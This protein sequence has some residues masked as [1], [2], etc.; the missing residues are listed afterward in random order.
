MD[1]RSATPRIDPTA[2]VA[3][4]ATLIGRVEVGPQASVW[5]GCVLRGDEE[6]ITVGPGSNVQDLTIV[7][8]DPGYPAVIGR[9]VTIG[10]GAVIHGCVLEDGCLVGIGAILLTGSR[11]GAGAL[12]AAGAV[13]REGFVVPAGS[14]VAGVPGKV[15][16]ELTPEERRRVAENAVTYIRLAAT[17][18]SS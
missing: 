4:T 10:H 17:Y 12:V 8:T 3:P 16:R 6:P 7:H 14:L 5:Y 11:V 15:L 13:V 9:N 1:F 2:F 18:R